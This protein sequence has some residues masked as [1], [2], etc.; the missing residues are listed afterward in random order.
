VGTADK[1][2]TNNFLKNLFKNGVIAFSAGKSPTRV[3]LLT[4]VTLTETQI[5]EIISIIEKS[6]L[7]TF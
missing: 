7:E 3:R 2:G 4:P 1:D 5:D 6:V